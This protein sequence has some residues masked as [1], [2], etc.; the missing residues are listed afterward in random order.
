VPSSVG[1]EEGALGV[2]WGPAER[3]GRG[4]WYGGVHPEDAPGRESRRR[5][6][7][8]PPHGKEGGPSATGDTTGEGA[9]GQ[10]HGAGVGVGRGRRWGRGGAPVHGGEVLPPGLEAVGGREA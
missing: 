7:P 2:R 4:R 8:F 5:T 6:Q 9:H 10:D 1:T 3:T